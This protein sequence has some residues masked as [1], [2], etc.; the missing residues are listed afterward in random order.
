MAGDGASTSN[1]SAAGRRL[2]PTRP[3]PDAAMM[4]LPSM[5]SQRSNR[6][7]WKSRYLYWI[8][9]PDGT[10][11]GASDTQTPGSSRGCRSL[12]EC[13]GSQQPSEGC[14]PTAQMDS[15]GRAGVYRTRNS[16]RAKDAA[17]PPIV[18]PARAGLTNPACIYLWMRLPAT[19]WPPSSPS[20]GS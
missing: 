15:P 1:S 20:S 19:S 14:S 18:A 10:E 4:R 6:P 7:S 12:S 8:E 2:P 9:T 3:T 16:S 11:T 5:A 17:A 13:A